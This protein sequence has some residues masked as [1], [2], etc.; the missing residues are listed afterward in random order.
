MP[1]HVHK[2]FVVLVCCLISSC[3]NFKNPPSESQQPQSY[4]PPGLADDTT[5]V[6]SGEQIFKSRCIVC[7]GVEGDRG[8]MNAANL[9]F[10]KIDS[11]SIVQTIMNGKGRM[12]PFNR[13]FSDSEMVN[14]V[15]YVKSLRTYAR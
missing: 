10:S 11:L 8:N 1:L 9:K 7:H 4:G 15:A 12:P 6:K 3:N 13:L 2:F 5:V 14:L